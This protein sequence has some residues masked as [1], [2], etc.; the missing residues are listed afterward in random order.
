[1]G[2]YALNFFY[3]WL[4]KFAS[5]FS[6]V[7]HPQDFHSD[8]YLT[9]AASRFT[10]EYWLRLGF[11]SPSCWFPVSDQSLGSHTTWFAIPVTPIPCWNKYALPQRISMQNMLLS[12]SMLF[13][14]HLSLHLGLLAG[15][16]WWNSNVDD[17]PK[18]YEVAINP[19]IKHMYDHIYVHNIRY[20]RVFLK[21]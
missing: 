21:L 6:A 11:V 7:R 2:F 8:Q 14:L 16:G 15:L 3:K 10:S 4:V 18:S 13:P 19:Q 17:D 12:C 1:M 5:S 20:I 9:I